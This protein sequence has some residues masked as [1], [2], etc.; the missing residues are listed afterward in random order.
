LRLYV[1]CFIAG[2][3]TALIRDFKMFSLETDIMEDQIALNKELQRLLALR[4]EKL[5]ELMDIEQQLISASKNVRGVVPSQNTSFGSQ[6]GIAR[7][8]VKS[9][10]EVETTSGH[11]MHYAKLTSMN[12]EKLGREGG[13]PRLIG[14]FL[15]GKKHGEEL[16]SIVHYCLRSGY[17]S[18]SKDFTRIVT[19]TLYNLNRKKK[20]YK[21]ATTRRWTLN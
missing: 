15:Q 10:A 2:I 12:V 6:A 20:I 5:Q 19:Q 18:D 7:S 4:T 16:A 21:D 11:A 14:S 8:P 13:L 17:K 1:Y 3:T 9:D